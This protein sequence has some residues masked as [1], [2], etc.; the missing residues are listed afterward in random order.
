MKRFTRLIIIPA[1]LSAPA[2]LAQEAVT[3]SG[4]EASGSGG[5]ASISTGQVAYTTLTGAEA[6]ITQGVQQPY[7]ILVLGNDEHGPIFLNVVA[8]PNPTVSTLMLRIESESMDGLRYELFDLNGRILAEKPIKD[9]ETIIP[10]DHYPAATYIL[11]VYSGRFE[12]K[13]FKI[14]KKS[15]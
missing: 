8:Y 3:A 7:E 6:I 15:I 14:V 5:S 13:T 1:F 11:K 12:A 2:L 9:A 4:T 10:V